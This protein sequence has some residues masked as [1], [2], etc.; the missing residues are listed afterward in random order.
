[1]ACLHD[2]I[3]EMPGG[4][5]ARV[6]E[7]GLNLSGGQRQRLALARVFLKNPPILVLDEATSA[8]DCINERKVQQAVAAARADRTTILVA[9]RLSTLIDTDRILVFEDGR[10][11]EH[12]P[13]EALLQ[14][15]GVFAEL[16]RHAAGEEVAEDA[17]Y[18]ERMTV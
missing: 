2:E 10:V 11:V 12:G 7:R 16:A 6:T 4:Y 15:N 5:S 3:E 8:L 14:S 18:A 9:H 1:M 17:R 13:Y